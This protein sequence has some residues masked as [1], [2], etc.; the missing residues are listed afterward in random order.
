MEGVVEIRAGHEIDNKEGD[1]VDADT[2]K[3]DKDTENAVVVAES[4]DLEVGDNDTKA[5]D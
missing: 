2:S 3:D 1:N 5:K 4:K